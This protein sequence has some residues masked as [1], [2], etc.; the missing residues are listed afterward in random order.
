MFYLLNELLHKAFQLIH[1]Y[2]RVLKLF[3]DFFAT[4][5]YC[6]LWYETRHIW[7]SANKTK[8]LEFL[9]RGTWGVHFLNH[10]FI[11][12]LSIYYKLPLFHSFLRS[13][14]LYI[15]QFL[16]H[17]HLELSPLTPNIPHSNRLHPLFKWTHVDF[18][19]R[20]RRRVRF[21]IQIPNQQQ[22]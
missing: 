7:Y 18:T 1:S 20:L 16:P 10:V 14:S 3:L 9:K 8:I 15:S 5:G 13:H 17:I 19:C 2:A 4:F 21:G 6:H 12:I 22:K 11:H